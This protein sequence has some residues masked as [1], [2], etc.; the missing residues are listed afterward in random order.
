MA[1]NFTQDQ[2][3]GVLGKFKPVL[4]DAVP[5]GDFSQDNV[6]GILGVFKPVLDEAAGAAPPVGIVIF[7]RRIENY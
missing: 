6:Q 4:D 3:Q 2:V 1:D 5:G 7:R